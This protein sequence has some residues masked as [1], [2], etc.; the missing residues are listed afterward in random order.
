MMENSILR[1]A[2]FVHDT[3]YDSLPVEV[4]DFTKK[5]LLDS[6]GCGIAG[7]TSDK[8]KWGIDFGKRMY[9]GQPEAT[10]LGYGN[11]LSKM[12]A[13]FVNAELINGL[14]YEA[15]GLHVPPYVIPPTLATAEIN[16]KSGK[17]LITAIAIAHEVGT[18]I[19]QGLIQ[20]KYIAE[21]GK[22]SGISPVF[23]PCSA[24]FGAAAGAA[25][26]DDF[27][28]NQTAHAMG[29]AGV[30]SP[31]P[32]QASMHRDLPVNSGKYLMAGW[33]A[34]T[35][36]TAAELIKSGHRGNLKVLDSEY[37]YWRFTGQAAWDAEKALNGLGSEWRFLTSTPYKQFP[38]CGMMHGGLECLT[39][40]IEEEQLRPDEIEYICAYLDPTSSEGMFHVEELDTQIDIQ[41]SVAYNMA[42]VAF[43]IKPGIRWQDRS[44]VNDP[45]IREFM[46]K[47]RTAVHPE[48]A[49]AQKKDPRARVISIEIK[50][51]GTVFTKELRFIKGTVTAGSCM[52]VS[53][54]E[55]IQKF[56]E[57]T[58]LFLPS[59]KTEAAIETL[60]NLEQAEN[61][62]KVMDLLHV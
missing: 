58:S 9:S 39:A 30:M 12:G 47:I 5:L 1:F 7:V 16:G 11:K 46:K 8:G 24:V 27:D 37:G 61:I 13:A 41:F 4:M 17:E 52:Y 20:Q 21:G 43:G 36:V 42:L 3:T 34:Q 45:K 50:A 40:L 49:E 55:R 35:G 23:G 60:L 31:V 51:R 57:N 32:S 26:A 18:R 28:L 59:Y 33:A 25:K 53:D 48:C 56:K 62:S 54:E 2:E 6:F 29:L 15:A 19:A 22:E 38:C 44:T 14:D 10:V